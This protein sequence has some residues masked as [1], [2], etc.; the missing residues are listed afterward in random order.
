MASAPATAAPPARRGRPI[1]G[2]LVAGVMVSV[3]L[4]AFIGYRAVA[5]WQRSATLLAG[6]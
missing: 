1:T 5:E 3:A 2:W 4:L 6:S